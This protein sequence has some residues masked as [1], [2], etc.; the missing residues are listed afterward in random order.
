MTM[1]IGRTRYTKVW[2]DSARSIDTTPRMDVEALKTDHG[3]PL[4]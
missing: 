3:V 2:H 1:M 4:V